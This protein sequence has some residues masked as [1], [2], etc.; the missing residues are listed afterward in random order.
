MKYKTIHIALNICSGYSL[1]NE[2]ECRKEF[3]RF[4]EENY[5]ESF[6]A[7]LKSE[8][9]R[10]RKDET[11]SWKSA[12][13]EEYFFSAKGGLSEYEIL[14]DIRYIMWDYLFLDR[15]DINPLC[16]CTGD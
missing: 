10:A 11:W 2:E 6:V 5:D 14:S 13:E 8:I 1:S 7:K 16:T 9:L 15:I 12:A 4:I 3:I